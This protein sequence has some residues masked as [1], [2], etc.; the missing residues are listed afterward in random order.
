MGTNSTTNIQRFQLQGFSTVGSEWQPT[1][2]IT[3]RFFGNGAF[4][5]F[6]QTGVFTVPAN[7]TSIR[8][9]VVGCGGGGA[10]GQN[11][12]A[13]GGGGGGGGF[14][15]GTF[16]VT[17]GT[18]YTI[19]IGNGGSAGGAGTNGGV[20]G[21]CSFGSLISAT[22]G[23]GG[24]YPNT[25]GTGGAG[26]GGSFQANGGAG[27]AGATLSGGGGYNAYGGGGGGAGSQAG[28]GGT[29]GNVLNTG[30]LAGHGGGIKNAANTTFPGDAFYSSG[31]NAAGTT[32]SEPS[33]AVFAPRF[34]FDV[35]TGTSASITGSANVFCG[36]GAGAYGSINNTY[37]SLAGVGGGGGGAQYAR[38]NGVSTP[39]GIGGGGGGG[40]GYNDGCLYASMVGSAGGSGLV[41]VEW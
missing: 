10:G 13:A 14:A 20:G 40:S 41:V 35:F 6:S 25:G 26:T 24:V 21:T 36:S 5:Q 11:N 30:S 23:N 39:G 17:P 4:V 32:T 29:G 2:F 7:I 1:N 28:A 16:T 18:N 31:L 3:P 8:V 34:N 37:R 15:Y 27:G 38:G 9:R 22:G 19:T 12:P 33:P